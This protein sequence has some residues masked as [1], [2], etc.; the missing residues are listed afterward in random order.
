[1]NQGHNNAVPKH[2]LCPSGGVKRTR[3]GVT[4]SSKTRAVTLT[5]ARCCFV[6][7]RRSRPP[8]RRHRYRIC[9]NQSNP[10]EKSARK[11]CAVSCCGYF[12][13][14]CVGG[15]F[16]KPS[17]LQTLHM[18]ACGHYDQRGM[19]MISSTVHGSTLQFQFHLVSQE[20]S[21]AGG[22]APVL[23]VC[24]GVQALII[25]CEIVQRKQSAWLR[26]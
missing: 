22:L 20:E 7:H 4:V 21:F 2:I 24:F 10:W 16:S 11:T 25:H 14:A 19:D 13:H 5:V 6:Q 23:V 18:C 12:Q 17:S 9:R 8:K 26:C 15:H 1:M 3:D